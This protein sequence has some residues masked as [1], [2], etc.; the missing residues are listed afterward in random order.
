[1]QEADIARA[2]NATEELR[3]DNLALEKQIQPRRLT[4]AQQVAIGTALASFSRLAREGTDNL[5]HQVIPYLLR[6]NAHLHPM[7]SLPFSLPNFLG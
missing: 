5:A 2:N 6:Y 3:T 7:V 4:R 1:L